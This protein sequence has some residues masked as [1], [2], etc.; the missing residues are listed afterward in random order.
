MGDAP[1]ICAGCS[2]A[3]GHCWTW[4]RCANVCLGS[5]L[6][7]LRRLWIVLV[8]LWLRIVWVRQPAPKLE[9]FFCSLRNRSLGLCFVVKGLLR[10][11]LPKRL[12]IGP[13]PRRLILRFLESCRLDCDAGL[14]GSDL[15]QTSWGKSTV[16]KLV[17]ALAE[18]AFWWIVFSKSCPM[19]FRKGLF[20][21]LPVDVCALLRSWSF[22]PCGQLSRRAVCRVVEG[23]AVKGGLGS[24][25]WQSILCGVE[26]WGL[27]HQL[28]WS[29]AWPPFG[30]FSSGADSGLA[31]QGNNA[32]HNDCRLCSLWPAREYTTN[33]RY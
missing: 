8:L 14:L 25:Q 27:I 26:I 31:T 10:T 30:V 18:L 28:P 1:G 7:R 29:G 19:C 12:V 9:F 23:N 5:Y 21:S 2:W 15:L 6:P 22:L 17:L 13:V 32:G 3:F 4:L 11:T 16:T 33:L 24:K 20:G